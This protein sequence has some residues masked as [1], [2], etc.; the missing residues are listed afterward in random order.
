MA[1]TLTF[2]TQQPDFSM[3]EARAVG[4]EEGVRLLR[5]HDW[6]RQFARFGDLAVAGKDCCPPGAFLTKPDQSFVH[7]YQLEPDCFGLVLTIPVPKKF[8]GLIP[9]KGWW[10]RDREAVDVES[11]MD[12][13][14]RFATQPNEEVMRQLG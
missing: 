6:A 8:L 11:L 7:V 13:V 3:T 4:P 1:E 2:E 9:M 5:Q 12:W 10:E 14:E